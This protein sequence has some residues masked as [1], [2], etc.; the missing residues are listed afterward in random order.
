MLYPPRRKSPTTVVCS[1]HDAFHFEKLFDRGCNRLSL[2]PCFTGVNVWLMVDEGSIGICGATGYGS[3]LESAADW[4][5]ACTANAFS[6]R[7]FRFKSRLD[8]MSVDLESSVILNSASRSFECID[9]GMASCSCDGQASYSCMMQYA[10]SAGVR[11]SQ[12]ELKYSQK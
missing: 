8:C 4:K 3:L 9:T 1:R 7:R 11:K 5:F 10:N 6:S 2:D 12:K